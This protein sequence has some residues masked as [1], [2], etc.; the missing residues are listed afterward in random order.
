MQGGRGKPWERRSRGEE[1]CRAVC[2]VLIERLYDSALLLN[3]D[4]CR[5]SCTCESKISLHSI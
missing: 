5:S 1:E 2:K 3:D 4:A